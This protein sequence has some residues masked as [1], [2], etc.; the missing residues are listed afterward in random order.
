[1]IVYDNN[2]CFGDAAQGFFHGEKA[3]FKEILHLVVDY[4]DG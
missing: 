3:L 2:L 1:M 4:Y